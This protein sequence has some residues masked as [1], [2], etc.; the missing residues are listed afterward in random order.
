[1]KE[2]MIKVLLSK[3]KKLFYSESHIEKITQAL[4]DINDIV[5]LPTRRKFKKDK[6][7]LQE[8]DSYKKEYENVLKQDKIITTI[9]LH[10]DNLKNKMEL[11]TNNL[12]N[13]YLNKGDYAGFQ[14][15][16]SEEALSSKI[17][18]LKL[19]IYKK[20]IE[21]LEREIESRLIA[22]KELS[23]KIMKT[24]PKNREVILRE[25][26]NL[27]YCL[28][29]YQC[30]KFG[31]ECGIKAY[32][33]RIKNSSLFDEYNYK[34]Y[35]EAKLKRVEKYAEFLIGDIA[36]KIKDQGGT[37][38][39]TLALYEY[40][41]EI[42]AYNHADIITKL[43]NNTFFMGYFY[44]IESNEKNAR[45]NYLN[46]LKKIEYKIRVLYDYGYKLVDDKLMSRIYKIKYS[47]L[48]YPWVNETITFNEVYSPYR[49]NTEYTVYEQ[50]VMEKI[51]AL[52]EGKYPIIMDG[53]KEI[54]EKRNF[55]EKIIKVLKNGDNQFNVD[56]ILTNNILLDFLNCFDRQDALSSLM[57]YF[58]NPYI[59]VNN[60][61]YASIIKFQ[62][63]I[64]L[65]SLFYYGHIDLDGSDSIKSFINTI[66]VDI[67]EQAAI[68][69]LNRV[70]QILTD[71][72]I[73]QDSNIFY[74]PAGIKSLSES[75]GF[76]GSTEDRLINKIRKD[77]TSAK[78]I[79]LPYT[80][81]SI[82]VQV[83]DGIKVNELI[84]NEGLKR[85][86]CPSIYKN[87]MVIDAKKIIVPPTLRY[88]Y[89]K[90]FYL[91]EVDFKS[92][93][94]SIILN[95]YQLLSLYL[96]EKCYKTPYM[97][98]YNSYCGIKKMRLKSYHSTF[99]N[100]VILDFDENFNWVLN[101]D[102]ESIYQF[103]EFYEL[104][105]NEIDNLIIYIANE[106]EKKVGI[107]IGALEGAITNIGNNEKTLRKTTQKM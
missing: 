16:D 74:L 56:R 25:I 97:D 70:Y 104:S 61:F 65:K 91:R 5:D 87:N 42:W 40:Y 9:D 83:L 95:D 105:Q 99:I 93:E 73:K 49:D 44:G 102:E 85:M 92:P 31:V 19:D 60:N 58:N 38:E 54:D 80:L 68:Y 88:I 64:S 36:K 90:A 10:S 86:Y 89:W 76:L 71:K 98:Y 12:L 39:T 11:L 6:K 50:I 30:Q 101:K 37:N 34:L 78:K 4:I 52:V 29:T 59:K 23:F 100:G 45:E 13:L 84:L 21:L 48:T 81:E 67:E 53:F 106:I 94:D 43:D 55:V 17:N 20:D 8:I 57:Q 24:R 63:K 77:L 1:M 15:L 62:D 69:Y 14:I 18:M 27:S 107:K 66:V 22:L 35:I 103:N 7:R 41:L 82:N 96:K 47:L 75:F 28:Y 32:K 3:V 46:N 72:F 33:E 51:E 79:V 2:K 26:T